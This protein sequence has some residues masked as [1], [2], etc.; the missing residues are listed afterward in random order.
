M[1]PALIIPV[2]NRY[3]L[4]DE[5]LASI[6]Y[7]IEDILIINNGIEKYEPNFSHLNITILN[8]P[9]NLGTSGSWNLGIKSYPHKPWWLISSNDTSFM[10]GTLEKICSQSGPDKFKLVSGFHCFS[11]GEQVVEKVGLFD[12]YIYPAYYEDNDYND[13]A[14]QLGIETTPVHGAEI[15]AHGGSQTVRSNENFAIKN[16]KTYQLNGDYYRS[17]VLSGDY[18]CKGWNLK[19]RRENEWF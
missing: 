15:D 14:T 9:S 12:E 8:M 10:P 18:T 1:I 19:R 5:A 17:K 16:N 11:L 2:L 13:R 3:D 4:L 7:P 6:D